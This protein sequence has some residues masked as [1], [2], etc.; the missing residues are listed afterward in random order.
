MSVNRF[1]ARTARSVDA[2]DCALEYARFAR[3]LRFYIP[4]I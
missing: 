1:V 4:V 3:P 2:L